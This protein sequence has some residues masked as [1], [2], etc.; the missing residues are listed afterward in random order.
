MELLDLLRK[1]NMKEAANRIFEM[2]RNR[3]EKLF[4]FVKGMKLST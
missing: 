1:N 2:A 4:R 3:K